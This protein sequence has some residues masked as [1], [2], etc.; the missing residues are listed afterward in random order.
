ME[1]VS[2]RYIDHEAL[3]DESILAFSFPQTRSYL[4]IKIKFMYFYSRIK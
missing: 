1:I 4:E 3:I 2:I